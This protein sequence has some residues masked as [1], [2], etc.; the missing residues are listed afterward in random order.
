MV[1]DAVPDRPVKPAGGLLPGGELVATGYGG[2]QIFR[3]PIIGEPE[4]H[5]EVRQ[6]IQAD[7]VVRIFG[8]ALQRIRIEGRG[9]RR[10]RIAEERVQVRVRYALVLQ[11]SEVRLEAEAV[12]R[13]RQEVEE[14]VVGDFEALDLRRWPVR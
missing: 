9:G 13:L 2:H 4:G 7:H 14:A 3:P 5:W 1:V 12:E 10:R 8:Q 6:F 11:I